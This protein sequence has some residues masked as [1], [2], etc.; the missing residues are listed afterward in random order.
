MLLSLHT[1]PLVSADI[2]VICGLLLGNF[3]TYGVQNELL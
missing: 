2:F 1:A 3:N